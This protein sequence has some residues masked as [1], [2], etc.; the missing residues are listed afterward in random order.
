[1]GFGIGHIRNPPIGGT[2]SMQQG[3]VKVSAASSMSERPAA[4]DMGESHE[5]EL[6]AVQVD[7]EDFLDELNGGRILRQRR[8]AKLRCSISENETS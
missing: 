8:V 7:A 2:S 1:M 5:A 6:F 4:D 3:H